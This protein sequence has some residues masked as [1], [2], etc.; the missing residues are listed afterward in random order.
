MAPSSVARRGSAPARSSNRI[1]STSLAWAARQ[2]GV[3]PA[4]L[5][6]SR[7]CEVGL[8]HNPRA[9]LAS[10]SAPASSTAVTSLTAS[11]R[12]WSVRGFGAHDTG[13]QRMWI[14][15]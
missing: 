3:A 11:T 15:A 1:A 8:T 6:Q 10:G 2:N 12:S 9:I 13:A 7:L 4:G 5:I 14:V